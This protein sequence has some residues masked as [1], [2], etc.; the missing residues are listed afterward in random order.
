MQCPACGYS[1]MQEETTD[2]TLSYRGKTITVRNLM[3]QFC[4]KCDEGVWDTES[5][6]RLDEAQSRLI[7]DV[8]RETST[9]IRRIRKALKLTQAQLAERLGLGKLAFSRY[10]RGKTQPS[11]AVVKLLRLIV[12]HPD[13]WDELQE[14]D[15]PPARTS[16]TSGATSRKPRAD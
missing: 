4:P 5:N 12:N 8:R 7:D 16:T 10:E 3:G 11:V 15:T 2:E 13:L 6:R 14:M 9:D 1:K